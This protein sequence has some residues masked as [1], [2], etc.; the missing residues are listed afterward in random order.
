MFLR[1]CSRM[2][3]NFLPCVRACARVCACVRVLFYVILWFVAD[4]NRRDE[5][6]TDED[7]RQDIKD[8]DR[9]KKARG[10]IK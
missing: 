2:P 1:M 8:E 4:E 6:T 5:G 10:K 3:G 9:T 7:V